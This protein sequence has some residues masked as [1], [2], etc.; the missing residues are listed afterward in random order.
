[1]NQGSPKRNIC[2]VWCWISVTEKVF[3]VI[4][5]YYTVQLEPQF[6]LKIVE[7]FGVYGYMAFFRSPDHGILYVSDEFKTLKS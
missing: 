7:W 1:M 2:T 4:S 3:W 5:L 6:L